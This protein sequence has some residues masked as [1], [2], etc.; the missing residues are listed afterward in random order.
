MRKIG[1]IGTD[2]DI[3]TRSE[4]LS[5]LYGNDQLML[6]QSRNDENY[7]TTDT[8][9][10]LVRQTDIIIV[11]QEAMQNLNLL[12]HTIKKGTR[13]FLDLKKPLPVSVI[14]KCKAYQE[15]AGNSVTFNIDAYYHL[16]KVFEQEILNPKHIH[17]EVFRSDEDLLDRF[18]HYLVFTCIFMGCENIQFTFQLIKGQN[19]KARAIVSNFYN[20]NEQYL[21]LALGS[22]D[23]GVNRFL[24]YDKE[25]ISENHFE[26][27]LSFNDRDILNCQITALLNKQDI[28]NL[29]CLMVISELMLKVMDAAEIKGFSL[30]GKN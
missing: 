19:D 22:Y 1:L 16:Q 11:G 21:H 18:Y 17:I 25:K 5:Q 24:V 14:K 6:L 30:K 9:E 20:L 7:N 10:E 12:Y 3:Q 8:V 29:N 26:E 27:A 23:S 2:A 28:G 13:V 15:E 4:M